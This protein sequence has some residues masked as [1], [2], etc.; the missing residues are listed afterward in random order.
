MISRRK[1]VRGITA[2]IAVPYI[3][4]AARGAEPMK[5]GHIMTANHHVNLAAQKFAEE[6]KTRTSGAIDVQLFP[7]GQLGQE[8]DMFESMRFGSLQLG[9][10]AG[11]AIEGFEPSEGL[12]SLP[13]LFKSYEHVFKVQD[14]PVGREVAQ[15]V[16]AKTGVRYLAYGHI[17]LRNTLTRS[18]AIRSVADFNGLKIRVPPSPSFVSAFKLLG[19]SPTAIPGGEMYTA[20][21]MGVVDGVE[22][23]PD[24]LSD[25]KMFEIA[26]NYTLTHHIY[27]D[28]PLVIADKVWQRLPPE[29]QKA[30][31]DA[32]RIAELYER[33]LAAE[34]EGKVFETIRSQGVQLIEIDTDSIRARMTSYYKEFADKIGGP[35]LIDDAIAAA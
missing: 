21:Q 3:V 31:T 34:L 7:S 8:K 28:I 22:G 10:I 23:T 11:N 5:L 24:I 27:T 1:V 32:A 25:F 4:R 12:F 26:K 17:G 14:G 20:L 19:A 29:H 18:K 9:Y 16:L 13:Y 2:G 35:K 15:R 33:K 6:V 30:L